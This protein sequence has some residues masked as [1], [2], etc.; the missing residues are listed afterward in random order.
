ALRFGAN[1]LGGAINFVTPSGRDAR[2][3]AMSADV[4]SFGYRRIQAS[5]GSA[6]GPFDY[7]VTGSYQVQ[8]GFR[9]HSN[10]NLMR[11]SANFGYRIA[12][13]IETR[14]YFNG[15]TIE[16]RIPGAVTKEIALSQPRLAQKVNVAN[17]WQRNVNSNRIANKTAIQLGDTMF[18]VGAFN[19]ERHLMHPI[20]QWLDYTY[21]DYG[22]FGRMVD[23]RKIFGFRNRL[24]AGV[25]IHNGEI[26]NQQFG[27][28]VMATKGVLMSSS[29][30]KSKNASAYAEN[31]FY[32]LP[33]VAAVAGTQF[34]RATRQRIDRFLSNGDQSG[35]TNFD[36]WSP[37]FGLLW[38]IDPTAQ[39][40]ANISRSAEVPSF[41]E[42]VA[43]VPFVAPNLPNIPFTDIKAQRATT[44]EIGTRG[45][46]PDYNWDIALYRSEIRNELQCLYSVFGNCSVTNADRTVH[47]GVEIGVGVAVMKSMLVQGAEPDKLW[48]QMAYT[49]NDFYFDN[50]ERFGNNR[51]PGIPP[52]YMRAELLY[53]HPS[54]IFF[55]PNVEWVPQGYFVDSVNSVTAD[56]YTLWGIRAG[57]EKDTNFSVYV[58]GRNLANEVYIASTSI[59][60]VAN[61][62]SALFEPG[63]G[64]AVFAGMKMKW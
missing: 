37:K 3:F 56:P 27:N 46:R 45:R 6:A 47:Q 39:V 10:G 15:N 48:L 8:D 41:G 43:P 64:R 16:Q 58:E 32:F 22:G 33:N 61:Q 30:D 9:E 21:D 29:L 18:E 36:I 31:S 35:E 63:N 13:N 34:L 59:I 19:V 20:F 38:D 44:Y 26:D 25:N 60:N 11:G 5:S 2:L 49:Y 24:V 12:P 51:L 57:Y 4:G 50:D 62:R 7:F 14:F 54:G 40:Y 53:K 1:S 55:G 52:Q 23:D 28:G 42:S 17:D